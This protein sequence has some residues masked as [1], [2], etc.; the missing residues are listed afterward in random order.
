[1]Q[2]PARG[3]PVF[4]KEAGDACENAIVKTGTG[5]VTRLAAADWKEP[6]KILSDLVLR[7][8]KTRAMEILDVGCGSGGTSKAFTAHGNV[9]GVDYSQLALKH[10]KGS[11]SVVR[12]SMTAIPF[13]SG[14]FD[15]V[16][17]LDAIEHEKNDREVLDEILRLLCPGGTL[18]V[19][20][21]AFQFL[22]SGHDVAVSHVRRYNLGQITRMVEEAGFTM[23]KSSYFVSFLFPF[24]AAYRLLP[25]KRSGKP[26]ANMV[27]FPALV[28]A[29]FEK[30]LD[31]ENW[32]IKRARLPFGLSVVVVAEKKQGAARGP[33]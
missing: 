24:V 7:H 11:I 3:P 9:V 33:D 20:V 15:L 32:I 4:G 30:M 1:M 19:T 29:V 2:A 14:A 26:E 22:W 25:S 10:A 27:R 17:I 6:G 21:P 28:N 31:L 8:C 5:P 12:S 13:K 16:T 18:I 23:L